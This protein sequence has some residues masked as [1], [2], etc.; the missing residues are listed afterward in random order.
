MGENYVLCAVNKLPAHTFPLRGAACCVF[1]SD[2]HTSVASVF[3]AYLA[4]VELRGWAS[5]LSA[6]KDAVFSLQGLAGSQQA[7]V[8]AALL[9]QAGRA[10]LVVVNER[11][12]AQYLQNDLALLL[13]DIQVL[14]FP[15][16]AR[17]PYQL[18]H[19]DNANVVERAEVLFAINQSAPG[20]LVVVT[21]PEAVA[22]KVIERKTLVRHTLPLSVG[23]KPG[24]AFIQSMLEEYGFT[25]TDFVYEP[26]QFA[27]R[28]GL[29]DL[30]TFNGEQPYRIEFDGEE[31]E[32]IRSF[33]PES[34]LS[35]QRH[36][37]IAII[38]NIQTHLQEEA[39]VSLLEYISPS[40]VV[41][42]QDVRFWLDETDKLMEKAQFI[43]GQGS[44]RGGDISLH[45]TPE[46]LYVKIEELKAEL[47][48]F[49]RVE[50]G[51][52]RYYKGGDFHTEVWE[53]TGKAQP[54]FKKEFGLLAE[55]LHGLQADG[56]HTLI[57]CENEK[58]ERRLT[59]IFQQ[60]KP[61]L[62]LTTTSDVISEGFY[63]AELKLAV[64]TDHQIFERY[65]RYSSRNAFNKS[66]AL[67]LKELL[68]LKPG[69]FI[70]HM[71]HG[72]G[73]FAGLEKI[74]QGETTQEA[75]KIVFEG[76][77][78][79]FVNVNAL[80]KITKYAGKEA[81][82]PKLSKL[83]TAEWA[84]TTAKVK[85]RVK[86]LAF[87]LVALYARRKTQPGMGFSPDTYMQQELEASFMYEDTPDQVKATEDI[88]RDMEAPHP[89]DRLVCG[90]VG[91]GKTEIAVRAAFKAATDGKQVAVLVPT[92]ILALQHYRTFSERLVQ[93]PVR[94]DFINRFRSATEQKD[95]LRE[96]AEGKI[97]ILIGTHRLLSKDV[98]YKDLGLLIIDEEHKFGVGA[99]E[100]IRAFK[101]SI[102]TLTLTATPIPRTLQFSLLGIRDL[103][104]IATPPPNRKPVDTILTGFDSAAIRDAIAFELKRRGQVFFVHNRIKDLE[105]IASMIKKLVPDARV[106]I[107][108]G[109]LEGDKLEEIMEN[110]VQGNYD[111]LVTT[112]IIESGLDISNANT[113]IINQAHTYGLSDLHQMRGRV[114]RSNRKAFCYLISPPVS[115]LP[116]DSRKRLQAIEEFNDLG[117]GLQVAMRDLDI[118]GAG[119]ILGQ[120]Q[121]GY[122]TEIG[123][124]MYN[125]ILDEAI[126]ELKEE[127]FPELL[128]NAERAYQ[129]ATD[130]CQ[131]ETD[132]IA[133]IPETYVRN[134]AE[135]LAIYKRISSAANETEL[136]TL[137]RELQDRFGLLPAEV[138]ALLDTIRLRELGKA[139]GFEK[140]TL[141]GNLLKLT[142]LGQKDSAYF[143][144]TVFAGIIGT[145]Q[146]LKH[147]LQL[148]QNGDV[149]TLVGKGFNG[150]KEALQLLRTLQVATLP[151]AL[152]T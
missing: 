81:G 149:L 121:S 75:V 112:T 15:S 93:L 79:L 150:V 28:G 8:L 94:V 19:V 142:F 117:S 36:D 62:Q 67:T 49:T 9:Q 51:K 7:F 127:H 97:D 135:R 147:G 80:H 72:I 47:K 23:E 16:S 60:L 73:R 76:G 111:V 44:E 31:I 27:V 133:L 39:R 90:D 128:T 57:C 95:V 32:S 34:Q 92:T 107:S 26:G 56:V 103:S 98:V 101:V 77:D 86:E 43:Y 122:I 148:K 11:E 22:E 114:G 100:K 151:V 124:D 115:T 141:R 113:I 2:M 38:P 71:Q 105:E 14:F 146:N 30:Y 12:D 17:R 74:K 4:Q 104:I 13:P 33:D 65:H 87:D 37:R 5:Q 110:F 46:K 91:F 138:L 84:R 109:Q 145:I 50:L 119:D 45:S 40:A 25:A 58:Q 99:K 48:T 35:S 3:S 118:R 82:L 6:S 120:E 129:N 21:Y 106:G 59:E 66:K 29:I 102:D 42:A 139:L 10:A 70:T 64:Y 83:G 55:H 125:R 134:V 54:L 116:T 53:W 140:I 18:D 131:I 89:M 24:M 52:K 1:K 20:Q 88:K 144:G 126:R 123:Y 132:T 96:L 136:Q 152:A 137:G 143:Q 85:R 63:D 130:D 41:F 108:H 68:S 69:D 61:D 78:T